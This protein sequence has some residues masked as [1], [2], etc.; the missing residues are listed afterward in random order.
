[1]IPVYMRFRRM[2]NTL[3]LTRN[4]VQRL[5]EDYFDIPSELREPPWTWFDEKLREYTKH[6]RNVE[7]RTSQSTVSAIQVHLA[8]DDA[9]STKAMRQKIP[10]QAEDGNATPIRLARRGPSIQGE[11]G[12]AAAV[13]LGV[14]ET[15]MRTEAKMENS[16]Y[17]HPEFVSQSFEVEAMLSSIDRE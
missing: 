5:V 7:P 1:M 17:K 8:D 14:K 15:F 12:S 10:I 11:K 2:V 16:C 9:V 3:R 4:H 6:D 13:S